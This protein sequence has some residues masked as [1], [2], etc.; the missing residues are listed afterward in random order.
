MRRRYPISRAVY[1]YKIKLKGREKRELRQARRKGQCTAR[2]VT[3][4]LIIL[5]AAKGVTLAKTAKRLECSEQTVINWRKWFLERRS[6]GAVTALMDLPRSGRPVTY[7]AQ[8][9][10]RVVAIVCETLH[11]HELPLSRFSITDLLTIVKQEAELDSLSHAS[12][13]RILAQN[14]L[15]PWRYR[16]WLFPRDPDFVKKA[17]RVLDLY[18]GLW[19]GQCLGPDDYVLSADEKTIQVLMRRHEDLPPTPGQTR[20]VE[21]EYKRLGTIAY[22]AAWDVFRGRLVGRIAPN[23]CIETFNQL[24]DLVMTQTPYKDAARVFWLIDGGPAHHPNTFPARLQAMYP[25]AIAVPLPTHARWLNQI[26]IVFSIV[27]R[28]VLTPMNV[29]DQ[30]TLSKRLIDFQDYYQQT[31]K[32]FACKFT[33]DHLRKRL[34]ELKPFAVA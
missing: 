29:P 25:N 31:A 26:E 5:W 16:Y 18:A 9:R 6:Q 21:F 13:G 15:K 8:E 11:K 10:T 3:R 20:R 19:R 34:D 4:I 17:C 2:L 24:V 14:A 30:E 32:P 1:K 27:Q 23:T 33:A 7:G 28:K 22:H 12:L